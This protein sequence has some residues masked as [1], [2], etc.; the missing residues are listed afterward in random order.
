MRSHATSGLVVGS[1]N[2]YLMW[3]REVLREAR[4]PVGSRGPQFCGPVVL[5]YPILSS[6]ILSYPIL[7]CP[8]LS[9]PILSCPVLSCPL[10][11]CDRL[12]CPILSYPIL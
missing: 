1:L 3:A 11:S 10:P 7:S 9:Y 4:W 6:P 8:L 12:F 5:S 2:G